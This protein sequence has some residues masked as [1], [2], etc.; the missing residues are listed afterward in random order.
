MARDGSFEIEPRLREP[1]DVRVVVAP[2][3]A[4]EEQRHSSPVML[5]L[6]KDAWKKRQ[7]KFTVEATL[8]VDRERL[9][10]LLG[11]TICISGHVRKIEKL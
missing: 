2:A 5:E 6:S 8:A 3:Q 10:F 9:T 11:R 7:N 4:D 1:A